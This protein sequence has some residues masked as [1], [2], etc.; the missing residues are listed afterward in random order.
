MKYNG[1]PQSKFED[2]LPEI[3]ISRYEGVGRMWVYEVWKYGY[4]RYGNMG[5]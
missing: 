2:I 4:M 5:I 3:V 1:D